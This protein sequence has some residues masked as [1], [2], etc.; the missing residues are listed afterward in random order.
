MS[1]IDSPGAKSVHDFS[2]FSNSSESEGSND[3]VGDL[4]TSGP[5]AGPKGL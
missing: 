1:N 5:F 3:N 4:I 2:S